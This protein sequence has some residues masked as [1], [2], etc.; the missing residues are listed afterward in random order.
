MDAWVWLII[1]D[2]LFFPFFTRDTFEVQSGRKNE[3]N[4]WERWA[5]GAQA[6]HVKQQWAKIACFEFAHVLKQIVI[7]TRF[8]KMKRWNSRERWGSWTQD[9]Y[10]KLRGF[11]DWFQSC[12]EDNIWLI[13][14]WNGWCLEDNCIKII[15]WYLEDNYMKMNEHKWQ[16]VKVN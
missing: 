7:E 6:I 13:D 10:V 8:G 5:P 11:I 2:W 4:P 12:L 1:I 3:K 16:I 9:M 14:L 15:K